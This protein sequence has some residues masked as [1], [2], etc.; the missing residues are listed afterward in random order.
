MKGARELDGENGI[1]I[2]GMKMTKKGTTVEYFIHVGLPKTANNFLKERF[3]PTLKDLCLC[4]IKRSHKRFMDYFYFA[5]DF[6]FDPSYARQLLRECSDPANAGSPHVISSEGFSGTPW[7]G[8]ILRK[9][10]FDRI[11]GIFEYPHIVV[12]LRNQ[13]D[14]LQSHY[15]HYIKH[16]ATVP[17][18]VFLRD[19]RHNLVWA[20][21]YLKY[22]YQV[23]YLID[24]FG[25]DRVSVLFYEDFRREPIEYLNQWC[26]ILGVE[27]DSW[28][29]SILNHRDNPSISPAF[30]PLVRF[31][32]KLTSSSKHPY[33]LLP[34]SLHAPFWK[35]MTRLSAKLPRRKSS[36]AIPKDA[37]DEFLKDCCDSNRLLEQIVGR[38]LEPLGYRKA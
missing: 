6:E 36:R 30:V 9:R 16:G 20:R 10:N 18:R 25:Q 27:R 8:A 15:L 13:A 1:I 3:F 34:R 26:D 2:W 23:K 35:L 17:W 21:D 38:D 12:V 32:S 7:N 5:S 19:Q 31:V 29:T 28:D 37:A 4:D 22:G 11:A 24:I 33:L 14:M